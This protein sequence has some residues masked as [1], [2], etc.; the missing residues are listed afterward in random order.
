MRWFFSLALIFLTSVGHAADRKR[1][2]FVGDS[3]T[4]AAG[5]VYFIDA[6]LFAKQPNLEFELINIGLSSETVCGLS[7]NPQPRPNVNNR[8]ARALELLKPDT[9]SIC[10]GMND[11]I[12]QP[13]DVKRFE[14]YRKGLMEGVVDRCEKAGS[15]VVLLT[16]F[17]FDPVP[18]AQKLVKKD[19]QNIG[20]GRF[21]EKY[22]DEVLQKYADYILSQQ[23][24]SR[25]VVD[26]HKALKDYVAERR[27]MKPDYTVAGDGVHP[28]FEGHREAAR[29]ILKSFFPNDVEGIDSFL[30]TVEKDRKDWFKLVQK[31]SKL[32]ADA[33]RNV[34][35]NPK[36]E[37][38]AEV[39]KQAA[40]LEKE[41][42]AQK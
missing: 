13:Y 40:A 1:V 10:Y 16:P 42:R 35:M 36:S 25:K 2:V 6:Y 20:Y 34:T 14:A 28:N 8:L 23:S 32:M 21:Y 31:R 17:P 37:V 39:M 29:V 9:V 4:Q 41:I 27:K 19:A 30:N 22:D 7:E 11:G 3:I 12:Y 18:V 24:D 15:K 5:Y 33:W 38:P 26:I